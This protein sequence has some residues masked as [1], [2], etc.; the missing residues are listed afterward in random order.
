MSNNL[1]FLIGSGFSIAAGFPSVEEI[2]N[3]LSKIREEEIQIHSSMAAKFLNGLPDNNRYSRWDE[4]LFVQEFINFYNIEV[5][6]GGQFNYEQ[7]YD[8]YSYFLSANKNEKIITKF[9]TR[10]ESENFET[11]P[12]CSAHDRVVNFNRT[13]N[14]LLAQC[15]SSSKISSII[16]LSTFSNYQGFISFIQENVKHR[17]IKIHSLNHDL[18]LDQI[19]SNTNDLWPNF[20]N[21]FELAGSPFYATWYEKFEALTDEPLKLRVLKIP[22]FTGNFRNR[23][24]LFKL[25]GSIDNYVVSEG[26]SVDRISIQVNYWELLKEKWNDINQSYSFIHLYDQAMPNFLSGTTYKM[27]FYEKDPY[28]KILFSHF[29]T[30]LCSSELIYV[31]GYGFKDEGINGYLEKYYLA[32]GKKMIVVEPF[33]PSPQLL[34]LSE[35]F[36]INIVPKKIE[37]MT[38]GD[39][40]QFL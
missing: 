24:S 11:N 37:Q 1:S 4:R 15:L 38:Y 12:I 17:E 16:P 28:Y 2:N 18:L 5:S 40:T 9:C 39:F 23:I 33:D 7:F 3:R 34:E 14:Q 35:K 29:R 27:S 30:N 25:H 31:I 19:G 13:F 6:K 26:N 32:A 21:G 36:S 20:C 8:F 10:F 22:Y